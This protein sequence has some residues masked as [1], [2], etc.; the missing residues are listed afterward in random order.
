MISAIV[1]KHKQM[2][3][4][5]KV[6]IIIYSLYGHIYKLSKHIKIGLDKGSNTTIFQ[7]PE[8]L[9]QESNQ[10]FLAYLQ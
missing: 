8:T 10:I 5:F 2:E 4:E 1:D 9:S 7:V 6:A 3:K